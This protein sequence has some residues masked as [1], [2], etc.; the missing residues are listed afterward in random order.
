MFKQHRGIENTSVIFLKGNQLNT[1]Y[2][3]VGHSPLEFFS[4]TI[5]IPDQASSSRSENIFPIV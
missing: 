1:N 3:K 2:P 5:S 4:H